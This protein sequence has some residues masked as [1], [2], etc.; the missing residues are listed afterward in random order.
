MYNR[1][2][3]TM[4][5]NK[6]MV[7]EYFR[8]INN[9]DID[10]LLDFFADDATIFEPFSKI[11]GGLQGKTAI[12]AFLEVALMASD[13]LQHEIRFEKQ[14]SDKYSNNSY[15]ENQVTALVTF[16][17]GGRLKAKF[18]FEL[19]SEENYDSQK[20]KKIQSMHI[21]FIE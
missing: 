4:L 2:H 8:L 1:T 3:A 16:V 5:V 19:G 6:T 9:K 20:L 7:Y 11:H 13:G 17:K 14:D 21:Q 10:R 12:R 15:N 18:T